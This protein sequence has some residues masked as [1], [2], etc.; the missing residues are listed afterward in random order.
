MKR[1]HRMLGNATGFTLLEV[2]L[3]LAVSAG[4]ATIA[5]VG[6]G[7]RFNN[8][9]FTS[10]VRSLESS[11]NAQFLD[12]QQG[13]TKR[14]RE[15]SCVPSGSS[16]ISITDSTGKSVGT[17]ANCVINGRV[18]VFTQNENKVVYRPI[19]SLT[20]PANA[21]SCNSV[22]GLE[23]LK[24]ND[25][26]RATVLAD[27]Q[28]TPTEYNYAD[29]LEQTSGTRAV[30]YVVEPESGEQFSLNFSSSGGY[31][32]R[33]NSGNFTGVSA[34]ASSAMIC[35]SMQNRTAT[36][37]FNNVSVVPTVNFNKECIA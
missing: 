21:G 11:V 27:D 30:G 22:T 1:S 3:F 6:L 14:S 19:V 7:P 5:L 16:G 24:S 15:I 29:S 25:C 12:A 20:A 26:Y 34:P 33:L 23:R 31:A 10:A 36:L 8:L 9:R 2:A 13:R 28:E 35:F 37:E 17:A 18:A 4:L 32:G